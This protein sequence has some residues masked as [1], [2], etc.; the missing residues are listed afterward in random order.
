MS[1]SS[2]QYNTGRH[3]PMDTSGKD[4]AVGWIDRGD[5]LVYAERDRHTGKLVAKTFPHLAGV[6]RKMERLRAAGIDCGR[7]DR[8]PYTIRRPK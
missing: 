2:R 5:H 7:S 3:I 4:P 8:W 1:W 6:K